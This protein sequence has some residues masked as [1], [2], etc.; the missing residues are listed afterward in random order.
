MLDKVK[1]YMLTRS[2]KEKNVLETEI[3]HMNRLFNLN[4]DGSHIKNLIVT[5]PYNATD[6]RLVTNLMNS[7]IFRGVAILDKK[8]NKIKKIIPFTRRN[9]FCE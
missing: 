7:L 3:N 2:L 9:R 1:V 6:F 5:K 8:S 4:L